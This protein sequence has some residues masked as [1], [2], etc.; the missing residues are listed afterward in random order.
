MSRT[1]NEI[2]LLFSNDGYDY[3]GVLT[4]PR[5]ATDSGNGTSS[6]SQLDTSVRTASSSGIGTSTS[7]PLRSVI[8]SNQEGNGNGTQNATDLHTRIV[9]ASG[10]ALGSSSIVAA[11]VLFCTSSGTGVSTETVVRITTAKRT[12]TSSGNGTTE[13]AIPKNAGRTLNDRIRMTPVWDKRKP[14][15]IRP[16]S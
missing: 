11:R 15:Y 2:G 13:V 9:N 10:F 8:R 4:T 12:G 6:S 16:R 7:V 14:R 5:T 3:S 1:Y